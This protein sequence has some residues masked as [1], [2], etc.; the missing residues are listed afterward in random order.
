VLQLIIVLAV[1][2][3][4]SW[5][6]TVVALVLIPI[7]LYPARRVGRRLQRLTRE[8]M[9]LDAH[10]SSTMTERFNVA[11]AM[12]A[13]L[14]GRPADEL[15]L[16]SG[17]AGRVRDIGVLTALWGS[18]LVT[19]LALLATL[20]TSVV[21][22]L[23]GLLVINHTLQLG[24]MVALAT[25]LSRL[26][27]PITSLSNVQ[28]NVMTALVSFDRVFEVLDLKPLI[29]ERAGAAVL[30]APRQNGSSP[31]ASGDWTAA[32]A[33]D[34]EFE[35]VSFRYPAAAEVSL[36]SLESIAVP[37]A[38][39]AGPG[40]QA[41][42]DV[43]FKAPAGKLT[44]L[45]GPSG[46]GKTTITH[47]VARM[48]D[49]TTGT[50]RI[51]GTDIR[52]VTLESLHDVVGVVTQ[53]A[54]LYHDTIRTN[55]LYARPA[56]SEHELVLACQAAQIWDLVAALPDGLDTIVG[57]RG[58]RLSG[59]EKQRIALARL[60]L[61]APSVVVLDEATAHLDSESE[62]AVQRALKT[63]LAGRTSLVIAHR[64]STIRE[65]DEI[66]VVD[67]GRIVEQGQHA[68]LLATEG[69][70]ADLYR[71]QFARQEAAVPASVPGGVPA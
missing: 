26:Y 54:H 53:D 19:G 16:F 15:S 29:A 71:T 50:V 55:L 4:Y 3:I 28:V 23:G 13:K 61:K 5:Q 25:L 65:A 66:L 47:L 32:G 12:L 39:R 36:A 9:Q 11:G 63:A 70:Y 60:L 2:F 30:T 17:R 59:G 67:G 14:Y 41:L 20:S 1:M 52:D 38:E 21:Y 51:G 33:P 44:A 22:G 31:V 7:F 43:T 69:L 64:L 10:M 24:A 62:A 37:V 35:Q 57:D 40:Q 8:S 42:T 58:Y 56:A 34:V 46:A 27:G 68:D 18:A 48:Y 45:V 6:I 49:P